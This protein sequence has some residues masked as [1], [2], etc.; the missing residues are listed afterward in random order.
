MIIDHCSFSW[1]TDEVLNT[2]YDVHDITIQWSIISEGLNCSTHPKGCHSKG[3]LLGG[4]GEDDNPGQGA[5]NI[6]FHHNLMAHNGERNPLINAEGLVDVVNN[7]AYNP[8]W[9]FSYIDMYYNNTPV[10]YVGNY[11]KRGVNSEGS[12]EINVVERGGSASIFL[13]G[14]IG[15]N[16]PTN[17]LPEVNV[18]KTRALP[19]V[20]TTHH[21]AP[22]I[23]TTD[24]FTAYQQVLEYAGATIGLDA[25]GD[26]FWRRDAVDERVANEVMTGTGKIIDDPSQVGGWPEL[27]PGTPVEDRDH[28]GMPDEW[29]THYQFD[30]DDP[31]DGSE[32]ADGDGYTNIEEYLN[33]TNP[34]D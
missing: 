26:T 24:A 16:R 1:A 12:A 28:D 15:P 23:T 2:W 17:E 3:A 19:Y 18:L 9:S 31:S 29:E 25:V 7:V 22:P 6:S 11:Y 20:V 14:N 5:M 4:F 27:A 32:D 21:N 30:P 13:L 10:N 34:K 8:I 33:S